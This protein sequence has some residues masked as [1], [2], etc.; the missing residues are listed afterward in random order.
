MHLGSTGYLD[1][2]M[3]FYIFA[4]IA[5]LVVI[6]CFVLIFIGFKL[7]KAGVKAGIARTQ[8]TDADL[9]KALQPYNL[10]KN[11]KDGTF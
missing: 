4:F 3:S 10:G 7:F 9:G 11:L 6:L 5:I 1:N 2:S 8:P